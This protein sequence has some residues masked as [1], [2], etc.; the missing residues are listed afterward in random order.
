MGGHAEHEPEGRGQR[1]LEGQD[2]VRGQARE[3]AARPLGVEQRSGQHRRRPGRAQDEGG[4]H[5]RMTGHVEDRP[6][7]VGREAVP[8]RGKRP[9]EPAPR[10]AVGPERPRRLVQGLRHHAR[11]AVVEGMGDRERRLDPFDALLHQ[12]HGAEEGRAHS[13]GM[14]R[15]A[16]VVTEPREGELQR[17]R[18]AAHRVRRLEHEHGPLGAGEGQGRGQPVRAGAD[19]HRVVGPAAHAVAQRAHTH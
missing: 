1:P 13:Q 8:A 5:Q 15:G 11:G 7:E 10:S 6:Q 2:R 3:Q 17:A 14:D 4:E 16:D 12:G 18:A 9:E 19:D